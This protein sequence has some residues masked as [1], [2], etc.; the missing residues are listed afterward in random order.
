M[1]I[2]NSADEEKLIE[3]NVIAI[4]PDGSEILNDEESNLISMDHVNVQE[5]DE[6]R[7]MRVKEELCEVKMEKV[8]NVYIFLYP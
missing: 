5:I 3:K 4:L 8:T 1:E 7:L 6:S 2:S